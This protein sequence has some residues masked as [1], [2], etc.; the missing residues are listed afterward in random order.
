M[1]FY[2]RDDIISSSEDETDISSAGAS[3]S[4]ISPT[5]G[6][7]SLGTSSINPATSTLLGTAH[8]D[9]DLDD[10][11]EQPTKDAKSPDQLA[12]GNV[13]QPSLAE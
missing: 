8:W 2:Q 5:C 6:P 4:Q 1:C 11:D 9:D 12:H 13:Y 3:S 10:D 7:A